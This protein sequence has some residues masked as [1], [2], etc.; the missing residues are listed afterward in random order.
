[1]RG[2]NGASGSDL[3]DNKDS[4]DGDFPVSSDD[5]VAAQ[6]VTNKQEHYFQCCANKKGVD[7]E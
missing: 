3:E 2:W 5:R 7:A 4:D 1:M 6:S